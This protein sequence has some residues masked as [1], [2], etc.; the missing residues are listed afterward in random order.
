MQVLKFGGTSVA[1]A[2]NIRKVISIAR[3]A[4]LKD[5]T[6][7]VVSALGGMTDILIETGFLAASHNPAYKEKLQ[8]FGQRHLLV[9]GELLPANK[10]TS[11]NTIVNE[12]CKELESICEAVFLLRELSPRTQDSIVSQG[13]LLSSLIISAA[14]ESMGVSNHWVDAREIIRTDS[15][16]GSA[17]P[18]FE[19]T[20]N[21]VESCISQK[22]S[23][24]FIIPGFIASDDKGVTTT[25]GRG[26]SDFTAAIIAAATD[27]AFLE[28]WTDVSGMMT[29]DPRV[30]PNAKTI[31]YISYKE[32]MELSHFGAKVIY[33]P[34]IQP[35]MKKGIPIWIK[36]T[37]SPEDYG[38]LIESS[39]SEN[40]NTV[41]GISSIGNMALLSLE[42]SGMV[43]IP[44]FSRRL[45][46]ALSDEKINVILITQS[47]SEHS[48]CA[49]IDELNIKRA[50][51]A[52]DAEFSIEIL[53]N[54]VEPLHI[55]TGLSIIALVGD[56]MKNHPGISGK[57][58]GALGR[59]SVNIRAI[60]QGSSEKNI[61]AVIST[62]DVKKAINVLH[63]EFFETAYKQLNLFV[64]GVG[65]V[66]SR[67]MSQLQEQQ[68]YL[69][70]KMHLQIRVVGMSNSKRMVL[71]EE[72]LDL[73]DWQEQ[74]KEGAKMNIT[75]FMAFAEF[76][77]CRCHFQ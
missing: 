69:L 16:F 72:G 7:I 45:F 46:G 29:A 32:A 28:I 6:I 35:V 74:L 55:E 42:G 44:G 43:G 30:V 33:P 27:A 56:N 20:L 49:A 73:H 52:V 23:K 22:S 39:V 64:I 51:L 47:S 14:F 15:G 77:V 50:K 40:K 8:D 63:E 70:D 68:A 1:T 48:I 41:R 75:E 18:N 36:N 12:R 10:L 54:K 31:P 57:M 38:T 62:I 19:V 76:R 66:G 59:N 21:T 60:A 53:A 17:S 4:I 67:L 13:E 5:D 37:F 25:L 11:I 61:S 24:L 58:F 9:A 34:T 3:Q 26:G 2:D 71:N 65:N